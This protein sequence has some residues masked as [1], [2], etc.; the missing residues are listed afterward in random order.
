M[1]PP[2]ARSTPN[3]S[4]SFSKNAFWFAFGAGG[5]SLPFGVDRSADGPAGSAGFR[6]AREATQLEAAAAP[7]TNARRVQVAA[8]KFAAKRAGADIVV[9]GPS[10][11][12]EP[13]AV[14]VERGL[15]MGV[16]FPQSRSCTS[17][18]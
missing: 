13:S 5:F 17:R 8:A 3:R 15:V 12:G 2:R 7:A 11:R 1:L 9:S 16:A 10:A 18:P 14:F 6:A 4:L